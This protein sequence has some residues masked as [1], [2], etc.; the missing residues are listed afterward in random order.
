MNSD[1]QFDESSPESLK[2]FLE[3]EKNLP[4]QEKRKN[5][6]MKI[7]DE[8]EQNTQRLEDIAHAAIEDISCSTIGHESYLDVIF[9][10]H[11]KNYNNIIDTEQTRLKH[12]QDVQSRDT[13]NNKKA[14]EWQ[15]KAIRLITDYPLSDFTRLMN[16]L[17]RQYN[18]LQK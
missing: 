17:N 9:D 11:L 6:I 8:W 4:Y 13:F 3:Y 14:E 15:E 7:N 5:L 16:N 18:Q 12:L 2:Q 10:Q 1:S